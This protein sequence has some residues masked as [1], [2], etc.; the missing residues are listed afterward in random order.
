VR[1]A[2]PSPFLSRSQGCKLLSSLL[3]LREKM[4]CGIFRFPSKGEKDQR[5]PQK[6]EALNL[7]LLL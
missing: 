3:V 7:F 5:N 2:H 6:Q 4:K 1:R